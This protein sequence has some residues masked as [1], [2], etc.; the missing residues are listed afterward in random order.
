[1]RTDRSKIDKFF[2]IGFIAVNE[3]RRIQLQF[4]TNR[5]KISPLEPE[6]QPAKGCATSVR[7]PMTSLHRPAAGNNVICHNFYLFLTVE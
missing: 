5:I 7:W 4:A 3:S 2:K 6:I 1:M